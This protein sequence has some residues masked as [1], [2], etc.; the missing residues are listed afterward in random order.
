MMFIF[1]RLNHDDRHQCVISFPG[2]NFCVPWILTLR[3]II[4]NVSWRVKCRLNCLA[5][6][7][8]SQHCPSPALPHSA[9]YMHSCLVGACSWAHGAWSL[10][11]W[12]MYHVLVEAQNGGSVI[13]DKI[14]F[15]GRNDW[16]RFCARIVSS[17]FE[18]HYVRDDRWDVAY[19][20]FPVLE[21]LFDIKL[22][23]G[24]F[25][26]ILS[27]RSSSRYL[28]ASVRCLNLVSTFFS[29]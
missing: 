8:V 1:D 23:E 17:G 13:V 5:W 10:N 27:W 21:H 3:L 28:Y 20:R 26:N 29:L 9:F 12:P 16:L 22:S 24:W 4:S 14:S 19:S 18:L 25:M 6:S 15:V 7:H 2:T 11:F